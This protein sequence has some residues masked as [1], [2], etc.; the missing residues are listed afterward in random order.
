M[1][2]DVEI[3]YK[4]KL[5]KAIELINSLKETKDNSVCLQL[6]QF[7]IKN[8]DRETLVEIPGLIEWMSETI[9]I[10]L[11]L[12]KSIRN[13]EWYNDFLM[14]YDNKLPLLD[15]PLDE[16]SINEIDIIINNCTLYSD[17]ESFKLLG[18]LLLNKFNSIP[19]FCRWS[20]GMFYAH[21][22]L[23]NK[24]SLLLDVTNN[25][26]RDTIMNSPNVMAYTI[27]LDKDNIDMVSTM[28][29]NS[30]RYKE[31]LKI[32]C[33]PLVIDIINDKVAEDERA[34]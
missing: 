27:A 23:N 17:H 20:E 9:V 24:F 4:D 11:E 15:L 25:E 8:I 31:T 1:T 34:Y 12:L 3:D 29:K 33:P 18:K 2:Q 16:L 22:Y 10:D 13:K 5:T 14:K 7:I 28:V 26:I 6:A 19:R 32:I 30:H 21:G